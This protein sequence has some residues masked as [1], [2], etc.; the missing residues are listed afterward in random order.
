MQEYVG[1]WLNAKTKLRLQKKC[2]DNKTNISA[3]MRQLVDAYLKNDLIITKSCTNET[4]NETT[5][6]K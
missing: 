4:D 5:N 3:V 2:L 1:M 6:E